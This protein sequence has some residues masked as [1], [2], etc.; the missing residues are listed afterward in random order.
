MNEAVEAVEDID[1]A[2]LVRVFRKIRTKRKEIAKKFK[3]EDDGL[4]EKQ[5]LIANNLLDFLNRTKQKAAPTPDGTAYRQKEMLPSC[6]DWDAFYKWIKK[7]DAFDFL[8]RRITVAAVVKFMDD[9]KDA[10]GEPMLPPGVRVNETWVIRVRA[11][12]EK[13]ED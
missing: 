2:Q 5:D 9:H 7:N 4:K 12:G 13:E 1:V 10:E 3:A 11:P 6:S 8:H